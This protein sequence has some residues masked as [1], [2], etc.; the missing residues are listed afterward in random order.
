MRR[1]TARGCE[2][3]VGIASQQEWAHSSYYASGKYS[4]V[5]S[6]W[7]TCLVSEG[8]GQRK[9]KSACCTSM[10]TSVLIPKPMLRKDRNP[11]MIVPV[12]PALGSGDRL[13]L[14]LSHQLV[15][16]KQNCRLLRGCV[17][18]LGGDL[19]EE[20]TPACTLTHAHTRVLFNLQDKI[21]HRQQQRITKECEL[22]IHD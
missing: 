9:G 4:V 18:K 7:S 16:L 14:R 2:S 19:S 17:K 5:Q 12:T 3:G 20:A 21:R 22:S 13:I 1:E 6:K 8:K 15:Q 10:T 11:D